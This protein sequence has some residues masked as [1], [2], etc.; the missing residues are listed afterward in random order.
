MDM[1][2]IGVMAMMLVMMGGLVGCGTK[3]GQDL[4]Q[5]VQHYGMVGG[6]LGPVGRVVGVGV[7]GVVTAVDAVIPDS[8]P[9][10]IDKG[11]VKDATARPGAI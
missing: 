2:K 7:A 3:A 9:T 4:D 1:K 10:E 5:R 11:E 8:A 6:I